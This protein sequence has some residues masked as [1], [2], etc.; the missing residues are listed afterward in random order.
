M[1]TIDGSTGE[2]GGQILRTAL[3]LSMI[4]GKP[5]LIEN[6]R[7][8]R[9]VPGLR[10]QHLAAVKLAA[11]IAS[12]ETTGDELGSKTLYFA[13]GQIK[14][15]VYSCDI[16]TAGS[17]SLLL[18]AV[19]FPLALQTSRSTL[20]LRGGT[21]VPASPS[22][23]FLSEIWLQAVS[24][25]GISCE[26]VLQ[27]AGYY[28]AGGGQIFTR[29]KPCE[30]IHPINRLERGPLKRVRG[31]AGVSNLDTEIATRMKHQILR[32]IEPVHRDVKINI[33]DLPSPGPGAFIFLMAEHEQSKYGFCGIG[34][35]GKRAE[36]V[37][38]EVVDEF[39]AT[40]RAPGAIDMHL[41]DQILLP[42]ALSDGS[43]VFS[44]P[45]VTTHL[46]TNAAM[47]SKFIPTAI[48]I[49]GEIGAPGHISIIPS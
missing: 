40:L 28:P 47:I 23:H 7:L 15:G 11:R 44:T 12:A 5:F 32:R 26:I 21:H 18:Q 46:L 37:A 38:N 17:T 39:F 48:E 41:S 6:I 14:S 43:S 3:S 30:K 31:Y 2:G 25:L 9:S 19:F 35:K 20:S 33:V 8:N 34:K 27:K 1:V 13:P 42:L 22:Y 45:V 29:I 16:G 10:P 36:I 49:Q 4:S 24:Q